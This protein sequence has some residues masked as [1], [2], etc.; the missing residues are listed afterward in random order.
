MLW[1]STESRF[2]K[3]PVSWILKSLNNFFTENHYSLNDLFSKFMFVELGLIF[4]EL[5]IFYC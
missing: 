1:K 5:T 4:T 3:I 2:V